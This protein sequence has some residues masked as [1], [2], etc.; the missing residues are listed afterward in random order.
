MA[1]LITPSKMRR[2]A[3]KG[4]TLVQEFFISNAPNGFTLVASIVGDPIFTLK[5]IIGSR[6]GPERSSRTMS[7]ASSRRPFERN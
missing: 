5:E 4:E 3:E 1:D 7:S 6:N 2:V